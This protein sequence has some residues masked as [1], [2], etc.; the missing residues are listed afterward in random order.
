MSSRPPRRRARRLARPDSYNVAARRQ[1]LGRAMALIGALIVLSLVGTALLARGDSGLAGDGQLRET[2]F[3]WEYSTGVEE[4]PPVNV[5]RVL[6]GDTLEVSAG[7]ELLRVRLFGVDAPERG[8]ACFDV[9]TERLRRLAGRQVRLLH[10]ERL[11]DE[12]GRELRYVFTP[13][14]ISIDAQLIVEGLATA[15]RRDGALRD[16]LVA[17]EEDAE[18][19]DCLATGS[20]P[21]SA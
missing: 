6:D 5:E 9:A 11:T 3:G 14:G 16:A 12:G 15:W 13:E 2:L 8:E 20:R 21:T 19:P 4:L 7:G 18:T 1:R 17:L 10:D